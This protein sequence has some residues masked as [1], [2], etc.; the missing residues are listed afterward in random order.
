ML[1]SVLIIVILLLCIK[2]MIVDLWLHPSK[3]NKNYYYKHFGSYTNN[4]LVDLAG[5]RSAY[6]VPSLASGI[7]YISNSLNYSGLDND[8]NDEA[9]GTG[10]FT[11][12]D[13]NKKDVRYLE[14]VINNNCWSKCMENNLSGKIVGST[15]NSICKSNPVSPK[16]KTTFGDTN[17]IYNRDISDTR[18]NDVLYYNNAVHIPWSIEYNNIMP[19]NPSIR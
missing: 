8:D 6:G 11:N 1:V 13:E 17:I 9:E 3:E 5:V 16:Y 10:N 15:C 4:D 2:T 19:A 14:N 7:N 12:N 18:F